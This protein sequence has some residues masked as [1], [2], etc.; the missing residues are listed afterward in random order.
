MDVTIDGPVLAWADRIVVNSPVMVISALGP[1]CQ[2]SFDDRKSISKDQQDGYNLCVPSERNPVCLF[3]GNDYR[4]YLL[5]MDL[6][7]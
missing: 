1:P 6:V 2:A 7:R 3:D 5:D 4:E